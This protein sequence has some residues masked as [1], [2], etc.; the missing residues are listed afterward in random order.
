MWE[1]YGDGRS[2]L[3][4]PRWAG[5]A[6]PQELQDHYAELCSSPTPL[7]DGRVRVRLQAPPQGRA[8]ALQERGGSAPLLFS[9]RVASRPGPWCVVS[10][11]LAGHGSCFQ[12]ER[13][14]ESGHVGRRFSNLP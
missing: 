8:A 1:G 2:M 13:V 11:D 14:Y 10:P 12:P 3:L 4:P 9:H 5:E 7:P 6:L